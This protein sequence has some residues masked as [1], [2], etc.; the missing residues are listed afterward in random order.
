M[1]ARHRNLLN[2]SGLYSLVN[3]VS[4]SNELYFGTCLRW[5][6]KTANSR[7]PNVGKSSWVGSFHPELLS[8]FPATHA[9]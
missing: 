3:S 8:G 6:A 9:V 5:T 7:C 2:A 1:T 4:S